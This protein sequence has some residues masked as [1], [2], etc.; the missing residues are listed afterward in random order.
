MHANIVDLRPQ[1]SLTK[2][3]LHSS[4]QH[5]LMILSQQKHLNSLKQH[6]YL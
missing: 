5:H 2:E 4:Q 6:A 1:L 3:I